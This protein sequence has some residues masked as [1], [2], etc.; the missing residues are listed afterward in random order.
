MTDAEIDAACHAAVRCADRTLCPPACQSAGT[1]E[2][3][4]KKCYWCGVPASGTALAG[5]YE[6]G[7]R[8]SRLGGR[9]ASCGD[10]GRAFYVWTPSKPP[11]GG[12]CE[13]R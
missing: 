3:N 5:L 6:N 2:G 10:H 8:V 1:R 13:Q 11:E 9:F 4:H 7:R 12:R